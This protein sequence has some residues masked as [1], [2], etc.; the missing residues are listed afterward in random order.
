MTGKRLI[1]MTGADWAE[2]EERAFDRDEARYQSTLGDYPDEPD[3][4]EIPLPDEPPEDWDYD[5]LDRE[6]TYYEGLAER[7]A[8]EP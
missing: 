3:E 1:D 7:W 6:P 8:L 4:D 5:P 2:V